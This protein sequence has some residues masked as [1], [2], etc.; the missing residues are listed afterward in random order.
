MDLYLTVVLDRF[1]FCGFEEFDRKLISSL[2]VEMGVWDGS[3]ES[4][5]LKVVA[6]Q[7]CL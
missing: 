3:S 6:C 1:S 7:M 2:L 5:S 4:G